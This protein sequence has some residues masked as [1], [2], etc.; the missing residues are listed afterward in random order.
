MNANRLMEIKWPSSTLYKHPLVDF[1]GTDCKHQIERLGIL[2]EMKDIKRLLEVDVL[3]V[4][5]SV[6][7]NFDNVV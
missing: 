7:D 2:K 6:S 3:H 1:V 4:D 5:M